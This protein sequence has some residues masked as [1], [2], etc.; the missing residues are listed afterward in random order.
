MSLNGSLFIYVTYGT[1]LGFVTWF[2][3][4][5]GFCN[6]F[7]LLACIF[8]CRFAEP[9]V[10]DIAHDQLVEC[11]NMGVCN[12]VTGVCQCHPGFE[13]SSTRSL[14]ITC[15]RPCVMLCIVI[16]CTSL[17]GVSLS[18]HSLC[19]RDLRASVLPVLAQTPGSPLKAY[20]AGK[21]GESTFLS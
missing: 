8:H 2:L 18:I 16:I 20:V 9:I 6:I 1:L 21:A 4:T 14:H 10:N 15:L 17:L 11:S 19:N 7:N 13:V 5:L 12:H 3:C